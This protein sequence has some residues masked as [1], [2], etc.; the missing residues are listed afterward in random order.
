[1]VSFTH[2][3]YATAMQCIEAQDKLLGRIMAAG[4][5]ADNCKDAAFCRQLDEW[6][7]DYHHSV[8]Q[9]D[10]EGR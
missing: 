10:F 9:M 5:F 8:Q 4:N 1:M 3:P 2:T 7:A 6:M